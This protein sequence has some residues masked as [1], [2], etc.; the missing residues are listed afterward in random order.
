MYSVFSQREIIHNVEP[1]RPWAAGLGWAVGGG[2]W[3]SHSTHQLGSL[4][5]TEDGTVYWRA[6]NESP[7]SRSLKHNLGLLKGHSPRKKRGLV[8]IASHQAPQL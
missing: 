5:H 1:E 3:P 8:S 4:T 2:W 6:A 7:Q